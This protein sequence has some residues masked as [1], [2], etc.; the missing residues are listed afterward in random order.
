ENCRSTTA[1]VSGASVW[2]EGGT[3]RVLLH[4]AGGALIGGLGGGG[5]GSAAAGAAGAGFASAFAGKL[6]GLAD[7]I[8]DATGS[9]TL[10]NV[11]SNVL[12]GAG[13]ALV[14]GSAGAFTAANADLYNRSTGNGDGKGGTGSDF[15]DRLGDALVSTATDPLGAL[16]HALNSIIPSP[17]GQNPSADPNPLV[18]ANDN[19]NPPATGGAV[20]TPP[21][22]I[23]TPN[24][25]CVTTPAIATPGTPG[26]GAGNTTLNSGNDDGEG[27]AAN[28]GASNIANYPSLK[29]QLADENLANIAA[30]DSRLATALDGSGKS[31]PNFSIGSGTAAEADQLG[32]LWVGDGAKMTSD[33]S[34][35]ISADGTRVYRMP[36]EKD[37]PY[38]T[39]GT[40]ANFETYTINA[41]TGQRAKIGNG[42]LNVTN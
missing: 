30:S 26:Y 21:T 18:Q 4:V 17:A 33:G 1:D 31:N 35:W 7:Q 36:N 8:G 22:M 27:Q 25:G 5:I 3:D 15:L 42:H 10:G 19:G 39:T 41:I 2:D 11:V 32:K 37:S 40:Q 24:A 28:S 29:G 6:N 20:V 23:C 38:A 34:G 13:G 9:M 14:G 12:A 16:N